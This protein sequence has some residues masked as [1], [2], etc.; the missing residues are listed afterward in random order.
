MKEHFAIQ[1]ITEWYSRQS[2]ADTLHDVGY[3]VGMGM[4]NS[5]VGDGGLYH[6][7]Y[8]SDMDGF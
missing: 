5:L 3:T 4:W 2:M 8:P 1:A 7:Y 6:H